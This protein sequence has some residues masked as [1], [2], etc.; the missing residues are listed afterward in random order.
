GG[1][2]PGNYHGP[3]YGQPGYQ[4]PAAPP[5]P[6]GG[7]PKKSG[8]RSPKAIILILVTVAALLVATVVGV[9]VFARWKGGDILASVTQCITNDDADVSF[10]TTPPFILQ[11][12]ND[13]YSEISVVTAG[14]QIQEA[15][16]MK[17]DVTLTGIKL[18]DTADSKG[19][20]E[21]ISAT[22]D[23]TAAGIKESLIENLPGGSFIDDV[24]TDGSDGSISIDV[25][26]GFF[27]TTFTAK[28]T[29]VNGALSM[30][31]TDDEDSEVQDIVNDLMEKL[32]DNY[33]LG[34]KADSVTVTD[35]GVSAQFSSQNA[36]IP[37]GSGEST[38]SKCFDEL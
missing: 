6:P 35:D 32:K 30:Q 1:E 19:T 23:W 27:G 14:N 38:V 15:V 18:E 24:T 37:R 20:I 3:P 13:E 26:A 17:A 11:Y 21:S 29:V 8:L 4:P 9:E 28:P 34:L 10:S 5:P 2:Q 12:L 16:G 25:G 36:T 22:I 7:K 31:I 33:P